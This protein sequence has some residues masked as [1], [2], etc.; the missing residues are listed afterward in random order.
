MKFKTDENIYPDLATSS[1]EQ[2]HDVRTV[3]DQGPFYLANRQ[4]L[5]C[6][7]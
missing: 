6:V 2:G 7:S 5:D 3:R 4:T 1:L